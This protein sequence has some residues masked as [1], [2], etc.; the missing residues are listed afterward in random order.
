M[1]RAPVHAVHSRLPP[2]GLAYRTLVAKPMGFLVAA[3]CQLARIQSCLLIES[4]IPQL[5]HFMLT[6]CQCGMAYPVAGP[7]D[8]CAVWTSCAKTSAVM[9]GCL[10]LTAALALPP[11]LLTATSCEVMRAALVLL[12]PFWDQM[13][14]LCGQGVVLTDLPVCTEG[15]P[16]ALLPFS[17]RP[18]I[19]CCQPVV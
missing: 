16:T 13:R 19:W 18:V 3:A 12:T 9:D 2:M 11:S 17:A 8:S 10:P 6:S 15:T 5:Q 14:C 7:S 1:R 4:P